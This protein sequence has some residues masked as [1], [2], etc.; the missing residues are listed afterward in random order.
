MKL[1]S[2][3]IDSY[4]SCRKT[5][6]PLHNNLTGLIGVNGAGKSNIL[7]AIMLMRKIYRAGSLTRDKESS[8]RSKCRIATEI[9]YQN[10]ILFMKGNV[11]YEADEHNYDEVYYSELKFNFREF[12]EYSE[13]ITIPTQFFKISRA[14]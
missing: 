3:E 7:N 14:V 8:S 13:W 5:K 6:F 1:K 10:K 2:F 12:I 9:E 11:I 4:R